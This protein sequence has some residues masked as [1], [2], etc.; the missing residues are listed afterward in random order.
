M[1][2]MATHLAIESLATVEDDGFGLSPAMDPATYTV[3]DVIYALVH[4]GLRLHPLGEQTRGNSDIS[5]SQRALRERPHQ[6]DGHK[7]PGC[8]CLRRNPDITSIE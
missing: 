1:E 8:S 5:V 2:E 3:E 6:V 7:F 4:D